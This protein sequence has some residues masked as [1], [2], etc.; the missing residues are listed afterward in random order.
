MKHGLITR[1]PKT[2]ERQW[3]RNPRQLS[4][5]INANNITVRENMGSVLL[6]CFIDSVET[7]TAVRCCGP[8]AFGAG[9]SSKISKLLLQGFLIV[10]ENARLKFSN[11]SYDWF[12]RYGWEVKDHTV[13]SVPGSIPAISISLGY[14]RKP[15]W[16]E[17]RNRHRWRAI[18]HLFATDTLWL[19]SSTPG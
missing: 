8:S 7:I 15:G 3:R 5:K 16:R 9:N 17:I 4:Q 14:L 10:H 2:K 11:R 18:C 19:I 1:H 13:D 12:K 6:V